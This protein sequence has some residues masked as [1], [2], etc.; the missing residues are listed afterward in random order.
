MNNN[1]AELRELL[2]KVEAQC[3]EE[4]TA[5][6]MSLLVAQMLDPSAEN[7]RVIQA[8]DALRHVGG[9]SGRMLRELASGMPFPLTHT[10]MSARAIFATHERRAKVLLPGVV[11]ALRAHTA[12]RAYA[13]AVVRNMARTEHHRVYR[14]S[15]GSFLVQTACAATNLLTMPGQVDPERATQQCLI[16]RIELS[17]SGSIGDPNDW[18]LETFRY[19]LDSWERLDVVTRRIDNMTASCEAQIMSE[20]GRG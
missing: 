15:H 6:H 11:A 3:L 1:D 14:F 10:A 13:T 5:M 4:R 2:D 9:A 16:D 8:R 17:I 18:G 7:D 20:V 19:T 12:P